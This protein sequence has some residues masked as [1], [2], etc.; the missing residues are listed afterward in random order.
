ML[1]NYAFKCFY[2]QDGEKNKLSESQEEHMQELS[3]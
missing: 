2:T 3:K 1:L